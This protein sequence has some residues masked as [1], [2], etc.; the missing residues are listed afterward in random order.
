MHSCLYIYRFMNVKHNTNNAQNIN[1]TL[2]KR[3]P[4]FLRA[5]GS[6]STTGD[7]RERGSAFFRIFNRTRESRR[8]FKENSS[9]HSRSGSRVWRPRRSPSN[10]RALEKPTAA[11][12]TYSL[13]RSLFKDWLRSTY[14]P[15]FGRIASETWTD[16]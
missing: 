14:G 10:D 12:W 16:A 8:G 13:P 5:G 15:P 6:G 7:P 3:R 9:N 2:I 1:A 11:V 4:A